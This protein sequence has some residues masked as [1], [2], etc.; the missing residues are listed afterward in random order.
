MPQLFMTTILF[1]LISSQIV[2]LNYGEAHI[3]FMKKL[4]GRDDLY[5]WPDI[6]DEWQVPVYDI[7]KTR[8]A[9]SVVETGKRGC[10]YKFFD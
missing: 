6:E 5:T 1:I 3:K 7:I 8:S 10:A 2:D 4:P 9:P